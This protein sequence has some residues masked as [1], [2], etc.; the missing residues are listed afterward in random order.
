MGVRTCIKVLSCTI[1]G[2]LLLV[3]FQNC[4]PTNFQPID[5]LQKQSVLR[6][7]GIFDD[8]PPASQYGE[9]GGSQGVYPT[10]GPFGG[11]FTEWI[12]TQGTFGARSAQWFAEHAPS[13][14][15]FGETGPNPSRDA[16]AGSEL[17]VE[18]VCSDAS[19]KRLGKNVLDAIR[20]EVVIKDSTGSIICTDNDSEKIF[21]NMMR[22]QGFI[23]TSFCASE[24]A[25]H[26][27][28]FV[29][30]K[31]DGVSV[32]K[33][34][35]ARDGEELPGQKV[36][37]SKTEVVDVIVDRNKDS[38]YEFMGQY[39]DAKASPLFVD[40]RRDTDQP[41]LL[42]SP[43]DGVLFDI[44]GANSD[45]FA[46]AK[47][48]ISWFHDPNFMFITLPDASGEI[49]GIDQLF[50][51]N[52]L[53]PD[54]RFAAD[55][56]AALAKYDGLGADGAADGFISSDDPI[57]DELRLWSD[58]NGD[59]RS[60]DRELFTLREMEV[61]LIDLRYDPNYSEVDQYGNVIKYKSVVRFTDQSLNPMFDVWFKVHEPEAK[62]SRGLASF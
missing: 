43:Y 51:D 60:Q 49:K 13:G 45:P 6:S 15:Y 7:K 52:T 61:E 30:V 62:R 57:F 55:G 40:M 31:A 46:H 23:D 12:T 48:L 11:S 32:L 54:R 5:D 34:R 56:F 28:Y 27:G 53:G 47:K 21:V 3:G 36:T 59:G 17:L 42:S 58:R 26:D 19:S 44:L 22:T 38:T 33:N 50:G 41:M 39:C 16:T 35:P 14:N 25:K 1:L 10:E 2:G 37:A 24:I 29:N 8:A 4:T 9:H 18:R 20:L